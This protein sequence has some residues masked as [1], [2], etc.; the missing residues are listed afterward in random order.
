LKN[1]LGLAVGFE[2]YRAYR[3]LMASDRF[4]RVLNS[5]ARMQRLL[6]AST[7]TKDPDASDTL[8]IEGLASPFTVNTMPDSTLEAFYDH[9]KVGTPVPSDGGEYV[10]LLE[11]FAKA[12]V[13]KEALALKLQDDGATSFS[14]AWSELLSRIDEQLAGAK[15]KS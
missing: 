3:E 15:E 5:G 4:Q 8:Y 9:G 11:R 6:W 13:D 12:G 7:G 14:S 2:T 1:K 10:T